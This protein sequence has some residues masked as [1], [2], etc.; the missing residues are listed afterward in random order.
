MTKPEFNWSNDDWALT[1]LPHVRVAVVHL[2]Q[3]NDGQEAALSEIAQH[4]LCA[5]TAPRM[6]RDKGTPALARVNDRRRIG[7]GSA[8]WANGRDDVAYA[9]PGI[10]RVTGYAPRAAQRQSPGCL[11]YCLGL[12]WRPRPGGWGSECGRSGRNATL[13]GISR[14][15]LEQKAP[16]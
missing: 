10:A 12:P 8:D 6:A 14:S 13:V 7:A 16:R 3:D 15:G 11:L 4:G 2:F 9:R 5:R 1:F